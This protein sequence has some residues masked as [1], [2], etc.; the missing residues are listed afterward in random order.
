MAQPNRRLM[1]AGSI[2]F[3]GLAFLA[4]GC[5]GGQNPNGGPGSIPDIAFSSSGSLDGSDAAN[6]TCTP[7]L[8][9]HGII[10]TNGFN[11]WGVNA[12]GPV[13]TPMS[14]LTSCAVDASDPAWSPDGSKIAFD[15]NRALNGQDGSN[16]S[17]PNIW[18]MNADGSGVTLLTTATAFGTQPAWSPDGSTIALPQI[19]G[20]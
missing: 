12:S 6:G 7:F 11:L 1:Q 8:T 5:G 17:A 16:G 9:N 20:Q 3:L 15:S 14:K 4:T 18:L 19:F 10:S 2:L 13:P